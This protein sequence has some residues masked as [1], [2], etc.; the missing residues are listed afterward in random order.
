LGA[1]NHSASASSIASPVAGSA[2]FASFATLGCGRHR[3][4]N[5]VNASAAPGPETRMTAM[6]LR[7]RAV[8]KAKIVSAPLTKRRK[9]R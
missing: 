9:L 8:D 4:A 5:A 7:P 2:S 6:A 1:G 3:G